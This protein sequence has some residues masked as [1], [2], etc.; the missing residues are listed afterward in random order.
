MIVLGSTIWW[1]YMSQ[2][3]TVNCTMVL[4]DFIYQWDHYTRLL[5]RHKKN[6]VGKIVVAVLDEP[7]QI[8]K[9]IIRDFRG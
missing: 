6:T 1:I 5:T 7:S 8:D 4:G 2:T 3:H 9:H